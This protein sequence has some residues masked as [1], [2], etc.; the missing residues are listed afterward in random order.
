M[1][2]RFFIVFHYFRHNGFKRSLVTSC[3]RSRPFNGA[4]WKW[5]MG[6][7]CGSCYRY[8]FTKYSKKKFWY[9]LA[10][11]EIWFEFS[12]EKTL[13]K[14][15][16]CQLAQFQRNIKK[17]KEMIRQFFLCNSKKNFSSYDVFSLLILTVYFKNS[18]VFSLRS[19]GHRRFF[20]LRGPRHQ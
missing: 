8:I 15:E 20:V 10:I 19:S 9:K 2:L 4:G 14:F 17:R 6:R 3:W 5:C 16:I 7:A 13:L 12:L 18:S 11:Q 1:N